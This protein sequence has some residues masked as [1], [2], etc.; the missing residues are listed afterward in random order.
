LKSIKS[1]QKKEKKE[2]SDKF[3]VAIHFKGQISTTVFPLAEVSFL[4]DILSSLES[5]WTQMPGGTR[6]NELQE[7]FP[8]VQK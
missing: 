1:A 4:R 7:K 3:Q 8:I 2:A 6:F 5:K